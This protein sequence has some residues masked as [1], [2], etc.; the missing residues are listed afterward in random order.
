MGLK[1]INK[2]AKEI[3]T[4]RTSCSPVGQT[5]QQQHP[6]I[7]RREECKRFKPWRD[8]INYSS[9]FEA[10]IIYRTA[11]D[12]ADWRWNRLEFKVHFW[13]EVIKI[14]HA[15]YIASRK[16][17]R[18]SFSYLS[19][20]C[21]RNKDIRTRDVNDFPVRDDVGRVLRVVREPA[22]RN[23]LSCSSINHCSLSCPS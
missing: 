3:V 23:F 2:S 4:W 5:S 15:K 7:G 10:P 17:L 16:P 22:K 21:N 20:R 6:L 11:P 19:S 14:T 13:S 18:I 12:E 8:L 1:A 9:F